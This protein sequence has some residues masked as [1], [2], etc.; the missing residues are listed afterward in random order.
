M[1]ELE[2]LGG[3]AG[4]ARDINELGWI[5]GYSQNAVGETRATLWRPRTPADLAT[6]ALRDEPSIP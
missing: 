5:V 4:T 2:T 6:Q 3:T 1:I